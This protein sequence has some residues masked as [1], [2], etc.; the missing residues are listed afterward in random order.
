MCNVKTSSVTT[1]M[2]NG[3]S[4]GYCSD[5]VFVLIY[6][7]FLYPHGV[8]DEISECQ[9]PR[10]EGAGDGGVGLRWC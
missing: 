1:S 7:M 4:P 3:C 2:G 10:G 5:D 8:L 9:F 6:S